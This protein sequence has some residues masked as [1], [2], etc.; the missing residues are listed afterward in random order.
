MFFKIY[1]I[2]LLINV[3]LSDNEQ[4]EGSASEQNSVINKRVFTGNDSSFGYKSH[5]KGNLKVNLFWWF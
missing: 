2:I 4:F 1:I 3:A 5:E